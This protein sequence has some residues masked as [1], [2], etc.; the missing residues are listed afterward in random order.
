MLL[1]RFALEY[2]YM[3]SRELFYKIKIRTLNKS[4]KPHPRWENSSIKHTFILTVFSRVLKC[5]GMW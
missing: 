3:I 1:L 5:T 2:L 4:L